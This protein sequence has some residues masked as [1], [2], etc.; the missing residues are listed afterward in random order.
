MARMVLLAM[1]WVVHGPLA[2]VAY[3]TVYPMIAEPP[4]SAGAI[5]VTSISFTVFASGS[6]VL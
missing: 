2:L 6:P 5:Q 3:S 1:E 4:S